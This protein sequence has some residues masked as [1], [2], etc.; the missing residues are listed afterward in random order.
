M[1][2]GWEGR[3]NKEMDGI[4]RKGR[5]LETEEVEKEKVRRGRWGG[6]ISYLCLLLQPH[7]GDIISN[8]YTS[9]VINGGEK[10]H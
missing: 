7:K 4:R 2:R 3:R 1:R 10:M 6:R 5:V 8:K 9:N